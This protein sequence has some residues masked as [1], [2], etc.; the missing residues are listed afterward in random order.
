VPSSDFIIKCNRTDGM[1]KM[2]HNFTIPEDLLDDL[3]CRFLISTKEAEEKRDYVISKCFQVEL[4][5]WFYLDMLQPQ[6]VGLKKVS[7]ENFAAIMFQHLPS[8]CQCNVKE[9]LKRWNDYKSVI[10][11]YG[12]IIINT[13]L[14]R[15]LMVQGFNKNGEKP[16]RWAFPK[17]KVNEGEKPHICAAREVLEETGCDVGGLINEDKYIERRIKGK[18]VRLYIVAGVSESST[19]L[20]TS[21]RGEISAIRWWD[22]D[23]IP[24]WCENKTKEQS[25]DVSRSALLF[26]KAIRMWIKKKINYRLEP[27]K[28]F[29]EEFRKIPSNAPEYLSSKHERSRPT[30]AIQGRIVDNIAVQESDT[31][32]EYDVKSK[33]IWRNA[34]TMRRQ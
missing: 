31:Y 6:T 5:Y 32:D 26:M 23:N 30:H 33:H 28:S 17:G 2:K 13:D 4:A 20:Q 29:M 25:P 7:M 9:A 11:V 16:G 12:A 24:T 15:V 14:K 27:P 3:A 19:T 22:L 21:T 18:T 34:S 8:L 10:P 1:Y